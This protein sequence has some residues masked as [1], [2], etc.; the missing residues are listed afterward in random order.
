[1]RPQT[2]PCAHCGSVF[3]KSS[4]KSWAEWEKQRFCKLVCANRAG[5]VGR[6]KTLP[7][8]VCHQYE[9]CAC[10]A[11]KA[12]GAKSC[13]VCWK[14]DGGWRPKHLEGVA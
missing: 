8:G 5:A 13:R 11:R 10:G 14:R 1:M 7:A 2:K 6:P 12:R 4:N 3:Y 9:T